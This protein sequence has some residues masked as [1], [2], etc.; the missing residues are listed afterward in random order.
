MFIQSYFY[1]IYEYRTINVRLYKNIFMLINQCVFPEILT[2]GIIF[3]RM[4]TIGSGL[5]YLFNLGSYS[6]SLSLS[7]IY[8]Y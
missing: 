1:Y 8:E 4:Y 2:K 5:Y 7:R 6:L 3:V